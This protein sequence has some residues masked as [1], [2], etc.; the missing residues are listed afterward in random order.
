MR[1]GSMGPTRRRLLGRLERVPPAMLEPLD[2][3]NQGA[4]RARAASLERLAWTPAALAR[5][6]FT[7]LTGEVPRSAL[8]ASPRVARGA[9]AM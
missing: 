3:R 2:E 8:R 5:D 4:R 6:E 9:C 1:D 7:G